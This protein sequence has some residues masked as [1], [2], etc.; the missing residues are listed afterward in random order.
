MDNNITRDLKQ[1]KQK[2]DDN[3]DPNKID[4]MDDIVIKTRDLKFQPDEDFETFNDIFKDI[5]VSIRPYYV[6]GKW[7][8]PIKAN[9]GDSFEG[10]ASWYGPDFHGKT[11][12]NGENYNMHDLTAAHKTLPFN[13]MLKIT[14][15]ENK[16]TTFV[17]INDRGPFIDDRIIDLS[18]SAAKELEVVGAGTAMVKLEVIGFDKE[19]N[20][21]NVASNTKIYPTTPKV[22]VQ[23]DKRSNF[24]NF[25]N[26]KTTQIQRKEIKRVDEAV[27]KDRFSIQIGAYKNL[28][29]AEVLKKQYGTVENKYRARVK[30]ISA[31]SEKVYKVWLS[32]FKSYDEAKGFIGKDARFANAFVIMGE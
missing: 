28:E 16:K 26:F 7:Y 20:F 22:K 9:V 3:Q 10:V 32:G 4:V 30:E 6:N 29:G 13:T 31:N 1:Q 25:N 27:F 8:Y 5:D 21:E 17:R 23:V 2:V 12:S 15:L 19:V 18:F 11:T 24:N 14:N